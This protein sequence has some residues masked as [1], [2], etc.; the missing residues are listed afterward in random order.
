M[1]TA[2]ALLLIYPPL[3]LASRSAHPLREPHHGRSLTTRTAVT[4]H[5]VADSLPARRTR[6]ISTLMAQLGKPYHWG[7]ASPR[8]GFDCSG[9]VYY[10]W[11]RALNVL[12][13]RTAH[14]M[15]R[16]SGARPVSRHQLEPGDM[17]F[18]SITGHEV[19]HVGVYLG[20][21]RFI[22][23]PHTGENVKIASLDSG[24]YSRTW[25]GARRILSQVHSVT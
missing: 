24:I 21:G 3:A 23:A 15:L 25:R 5:P 18:F 10:T 14:E 6:L 22:E 16:Q 11:R 1:R 12:L 20:K 17:L 8:T 4:E 2:L 13:P 19:D 7:G 9:L